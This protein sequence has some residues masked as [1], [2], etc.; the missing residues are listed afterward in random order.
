MT[1]A[2]GQP[3]AE[4]PSPQAGGAFASSDSTEFELYKLAIEMVDRISGGRALANT[5]FGDS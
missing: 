1:G 3:S 4:A 2:G 5:F